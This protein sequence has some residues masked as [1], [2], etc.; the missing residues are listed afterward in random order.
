[1]DCFTKTKKKH[2]SC[3]G[4]WDL[5]SI[6]PS[7]FIVDH[8][9]NKNKC[10]FIISKLSFKI[11]KNHVKNVNGILTWIINSKIITMLYKNIDKMLNL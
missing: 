8:F 4:K 3:K 10:F 5:L 7:K 9:K 11:K 6:T 1:M 2:D